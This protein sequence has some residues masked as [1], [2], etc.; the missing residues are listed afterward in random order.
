M[1][2]YA[3]LGDI[4][5]P[6]YIIEII[7]TTAILLVHD[8]YTCITGGCQGA[9][10]TFANGTLVAGGSVTIHLPWQSFESAWVNKLPKERAT[11]VVLQENDFD[12][13]NSVRNFHPAYE[14]LTPSVRA[15]NARYFN[16]LNDVSFLIC[17]T[18]EG[19]LIGSTG[20]AMRLATYL[21][22]PLYNLGIQET[23]DK[24]VS[25]IQQRLPELEPYRSISSG[26]F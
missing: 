14:K 4:Q 17:W 7:R 9:E 11:I 22:I 23:L 10:Q 15:I 19:Q 18:K 5:T 24:M 1:K 21:H 2:T 20:Q 8:G 12:A 26:I 6:E 3:G 25:K 13:Y 16:I